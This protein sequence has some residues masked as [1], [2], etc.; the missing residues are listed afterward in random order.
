MLDAMRER[1]EW[2]VGVSDYLVAIYGGGKG[3]TR[4]CCYRW[5]R[6]HFGKNLRRID[7]RDFGREA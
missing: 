2:I 5:D 1:N 6:L 4:D 3:G 7:P